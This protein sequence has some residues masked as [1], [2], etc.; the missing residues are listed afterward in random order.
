MIQTC[1]EIVDRVQNSRVD[2]IRYINAFNF[3]ISEIVE[4][5][6]DGANVGAVESFERTQKLI[7]ELY[8]IV[9]K[10]GTLVPV[11]NYLTRPANYLHLILN[12]VLI[13]GSNAWARPITHSVLAANKNNPFKSPKVPK[14]IFYTQDATG[15]E[16]HYGTGTFSSAVL[17]YLKNPATVSVGNPDDE[18]L[19]GAAVLTI[20][21][22]YSVIEDAVAAGISYYESES[23]VA[24][25][26]VLTSGI[27]VPTSVLVN[28]DLPTVLHEEIVIRAAEKILSDLQSFDSS[29]AADVQAEKQ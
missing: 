1:S 14:R 7:D 15:I 25:T 21:V 5:K 16:V 19:P 11:N 26:A 17:T 28:C 2:N 3:V 4:K 18:I 13:N 12:E 24:T 9:V 22:N 27:V 8:T 20:G 23:F 10:S 29:K 6:Y